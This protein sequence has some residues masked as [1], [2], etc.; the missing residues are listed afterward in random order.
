MTDRQRTGRTWA[1]ACGRSGVRASV[2]V[3][4]H[5]W[6]GGRASGRA[7]DE[8]ADERTGSADGDGRASVEQRSVVRRRRISF[9][10]SALHSAS[11]R[12]T[13]PLLRADVESRH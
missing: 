4:G 10:W 13:A 3:G 1:V 8:R 6:V 11:W 2:W 7:A 5:V 12:F 9:R